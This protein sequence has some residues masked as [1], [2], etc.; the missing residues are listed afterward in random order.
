MAGMEWLVNGFPPKLSCAPGIAN[1]L[2]I[3]ALIL[4]LLQVKIGPIVKSSNFLREASA[5]IFYTKP[6][7]IQFS[8]TKTI[9]CAEH[10]CP[11][12]A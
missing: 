9:D 10:F 1:I 6:A 7:L 11:E 8:W 2:S 5:L 3:W 12:A 4:E